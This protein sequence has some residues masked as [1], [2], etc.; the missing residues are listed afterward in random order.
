MHV[1]HASLLRL[2]LLS[3]LLLPAVALAEETRCTSV[4]GAGQHDD[5]VVPDGA[6][7][8][9]RGTR[10]K[11][12]IKVGTGAS[13]N[14]TAIQ[15]TG[16]L[17][18]EGARSI[19]VSGNSRVGGSVQLKQGG[20]VRVTGARIDGDLQLE[21]NRAAQ[22]ATGNTVGGNLQAMQNRGGVQLSGNRIDGDLQ[23]KQNT[24][25]PRGSGNRA[26]SKQDQCSAL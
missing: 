14:A 26:A 9:L 2:A 8:T 19:A 12:S 23:C 4:L 25:A 3:T 10:A 11:G 7:C 1:P 15:V 20:A 13:L 6:S 24:P 18:A 16:N 5:I 21:A 17:Q 22:S